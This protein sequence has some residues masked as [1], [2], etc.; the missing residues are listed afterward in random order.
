ML[1]MS[2]YRSITLNTVLTTRSLLLKSKSS[3]SLR[4][5][6]TLRRNHICRGTPSVSY[7]VSVS[8]AL[9]NIPC[10]FAVL[11][12]HLWPVQLYH[13]FPHYLRNDT[14]SGKKNTVYKCVFWVSLNILSEIF[15]YL[16]II[17]KDVI[18]NVYR[19]SCTVPLFLSGCNQTSLFWTEFGKIFKYQRA[20]KSVNLNS[21]RFKQMLI[22]ATQN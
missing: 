17:Q 5:T 9:A 2:T 8:A 20:W 18:I 16:R 4:I 10:A 15:L 13:I 22:W 7:P 21:W 3:G 6:Q 19:S 11:D 14:F 1:L 12:C